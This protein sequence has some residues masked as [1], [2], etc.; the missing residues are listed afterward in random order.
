MRG[1]L[2]RGRRDRLQETPEITSYMYASSAG[3]NLDFGLMPN[4]G[5][6]SWG[7]GHA[8]KQAPNDKHAEEAIAKLAQQLQQKKEKGEQKVSQQRRIVQ[9]YIVDPDERVPLKHAL[10]Y[11]DSKPHFTDL[12]DQELYF[13]LDMKDILEKHNEKRV[14]ILNKKASE[15]SGKDIFLDPV[16]LR[17]LKMAVVNVA[18]F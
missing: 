9:I 12:T 15:Q 11:S 1:R 2:K 8:Q 3:S 6:V 4:Q 5:V 18:T 17:D 10:L 7:L 13:E 16:K 14:G